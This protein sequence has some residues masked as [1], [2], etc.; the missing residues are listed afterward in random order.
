MRSIL[1][2]F[3]AVSLAALV[4]VGGVTAASAAAAP[5]R[6]DPGTDLSIAVT[7][8]RAY[9]WN[10]APSEPIGSWYSLAGAYS[11][12]SSGATNF[13]RRNGTGWYTVWF[14]NVPAV[15]ATVQVTG[16]GADDT[17][18][19]VE[20]WRA[21]S[22]GA[23][24]TDADVRCFN[25]SGGPANA[26]FTISQTYRGF[27]AGAYLWADTPGT[28]STAY[29][30]NSTGGT[31]TMTNPSTGVFEVRLPGLGGTGGHVEVTGY[32]ADGR[33]CKVGGWSP[34]GGAQNVTVHCFTAA[35][36][37]SNALFTLSYVENTNLLLAAAPTQSAYAWVTGAGAPTAFY[38]FDTNPGANI[39]VE[40]WTVGGYR[41]HLPVDLTRG[42][43]HVT[44]YGSGTARCKIT[45]W[46]TV[47]G[48]AV[49]CYRPDGG[50]TDSFFDIAFVG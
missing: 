47:D 16:Y 50:F 36:A 48:A 49:D 13:A 1:T 11:A 46:N 24:G 44:A 37:P 26:M 40:H 18:C 25:R 35:G 4:V 14:P 8:A 34:A 3:G 38:A 39:N 17:Y 2:M 9:A 12:N 29:Q 31:N 28:P 21:P 5:D 32:A 19:T 30:Y 42:L 41:V 10:F 15:G 6:P 23:P 22:D 27:G 45:H 20:W 7:D 33:W 43:V